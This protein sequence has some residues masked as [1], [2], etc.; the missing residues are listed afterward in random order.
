M[1]IYAKR[2][3]SAE[4][5]EQYDAEFTKLKMSSSLEPKDLENF[6]A[7]FERELE[8]VCMVGLSSERSEAAHHMT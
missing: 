6:S 1:L 2:T 8:F 3:L 7:T 4:E 5:Y